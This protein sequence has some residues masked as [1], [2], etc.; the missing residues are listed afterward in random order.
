MTY[1]PYL[2][3][4]RK[5]LFPFGWGL[6]YTSFHFDNLRV[7][8]AEIATGAETVVSVDVTNTGDRAGDEVAQLYIHQRLASVTRPVKEL[9]GFQ[10]VTLRPGE[11]ETVQFRLT[12]SE[13]ELLDRDM[14]SVVEPGTFDLMIGPNSQDTAAVALQVVKK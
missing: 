11:K 13:L 14:H 8:P 10:R 5:P 6:S 3:H 9:R 4:S 7:K 1:R 12:P 2:F